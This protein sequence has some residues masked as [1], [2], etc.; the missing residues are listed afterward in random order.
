M[1]E[2]LPFVP[3]AVLLLISI[4][5]ESKDFDLA[6]KNIKGALKELRDQSEAYQR[7]NS[8]EKFKQTSPLDFDI[9]LHGGLDLF[10]DSGSCMNLMCRLERAENLV[11]SLGLIADRIWVTDL[12]TEKFVNFG[13]ITNK[14][15]DEILSDAMV[16]ASVWPL[17]QAGILRFRSP[18]AVSCTPCL[19]YFENSV[20]SITDKVLGEFSREIKVIKRADGYYS[21]NTGSFFEPQLWLRTMT[22]FEN[23]PKSKQVAASMIY[24]QIHSALWLSREASYTGGA[25]FSN[26]RVGLSGLLE[27]EGRFINKA[28]LMFLDDQRSLQIPW[29]D[30]LNAAQIIELRSEAI[31]ALPLFRERI[32]GVLTAKDPIQLNS[33]ALIDLMQ[34]LREQAVEVRSELETTQ[35]S[36]ARFWKSTYALLG[37]GLSA[38][39]VANDQILPGV[40]GLL[41]LINLLINH[42]A[43]HEKDLDKLSYRP[44]Y[45]L[46]KAQDI[47]AHAH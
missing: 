19:Q 41:P 33:N 34:E 16:L 45:V 14:K 44:G 26:S 15:L 13:R 20:E 7:K 17:I 25:V 12:L 24:E 21:I 30:K 40:A 37:L 31:K 47:L 3:P 8:Y 22:K 32:A 4:L 29:V 39:G 10:A 18:W 46:V 5:A 43:G 2:D 38:Y 27:Q 28:Q 23:S 42:K 35:K 36:S 9:H 1:L 6:R 11:R